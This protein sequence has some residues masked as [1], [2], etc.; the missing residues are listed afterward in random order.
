MS[1]LATILKHGSHSLASGLSSAVGAFAASVIVARLLG[2]E[3]TAAVAMGLWL[4]FLTITLADVGI[5]GSLVRFAAECPQE[6]GGQAARKLA[7]YGMRILLRAIVAGLLL[8]ALI[9]WFYWGDIQ[10]KYAADRQEGLIFCALIMTCFVVHMLFAFAFQFLRG[11]R[12]F[13]SIT[14]YSLL[15][16]GCQIVAVTLGSTYYGANGALA[17]YIVVSLPML[18]TL[19]KIPFAGP[20]ERPVAIDRMRRYAGTFYL[21]TLFSPLLWVRADLLIVDQVLG[22][23]AVGLFAAAGTIAALLLGVCAMVCHALLPNIVHAGKDDAERFEQASRIAV[24]L[25]LVL[26]V[27]ACLIAAAAAPEAITAIFGRDFAEGGVAANILCIA[28]LGSILTLVIS[29]VLGAGDSN[30]VVARNG[31]IGAVV[32]VVS[33]TVLATLFGLIGA[34]LGR[35]FSQVVIGLLNVRSAN[36]KISGLVPASWVFRILVAGAIGAFVTEAAG[37]WLGGSLPAIF[38]SLAAGGVTYLLV[39]L[40]LLPLSSEERGQLLTG[41]DA[42]PHAV[43]GPT[44]WLLSLGRSG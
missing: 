34:A 26:L 16:T 2:V 8:T 1:F 18:F 32:T 24:R 6:D 28:G 14:R 13:S 36:R 5:N 27:P 43:R 12:S 10:S 37:W 44:R 38:L 31:A 9:L 11:T 25:A 35:L 39:I 41:L 19:R 20:V 33:G 29:N 4:V 30:S 40:P 17:G 21:A 23:V 3:G 42:V 22:A 7:A 15:G